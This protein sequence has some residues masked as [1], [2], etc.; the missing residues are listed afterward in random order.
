VA[1]LAAISA[2]S[3]TGRLVLFTAVP[4]ADSGS[5]GMHHTA[6]DLMILQERKLQDNALLRGL[7]MQL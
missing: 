6:I 2:I 1:Q 7:L 5:T 3:S 4:C